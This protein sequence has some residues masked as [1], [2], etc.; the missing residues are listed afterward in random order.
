MILN[1]NTKRIMHRVKSIYSLYSFLILRSSWLGIGYQFNVGH[2]NLLCDSH[3]STQFQSINNIGV[4]V[5][6]EQMNEVQ[7]LLLDRE[8]KSGRIWVLAALGHW[9][10][11]EDLSPTVFLIV[12]VPVLLI[13]Q[14][15]LLD[16]QLWNIRWKE[17]KISSF[18]MEL[19]SYKM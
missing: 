10:F 17:K 5:M 11:A 2:L 14:Q 15:K 4:F 8:F 19:L 1:L 6:P 12:K 13:R 3:F 9:D 7:Y 16:I 18:K